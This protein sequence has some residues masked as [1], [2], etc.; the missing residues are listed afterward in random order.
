MGISRLQCNVGEPE[1]TRERVHCGAEH[2]GRDRCYPGKALDE[3]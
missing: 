3:A 1:L 2:D